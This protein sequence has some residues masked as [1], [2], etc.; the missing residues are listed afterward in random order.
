MGDGCFDLQCKIS[1]RSLVLV[2]SEKLHEKDVSFSSFSLLWV[3]CV[4]QLGA[5]DSPG[6]R[7]NE[8]PNSPVISISRSLNQALS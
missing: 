7:E 6:E 5:I 3:C 8:A 2:F 4:S 1:M